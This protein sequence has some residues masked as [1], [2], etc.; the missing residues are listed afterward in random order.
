M[1]DVRQAAGCKIEAV[2]RTVRTRITEWEL[3]NII[4]VGLAINGIRAEQGE[5]GWG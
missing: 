3:K 5:R 1:V 2:T 4:I